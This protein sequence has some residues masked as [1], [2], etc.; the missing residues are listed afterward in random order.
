[1]PIKKMFSA[2][3]NAAETILNNLSQQFSCKKNYFYIS[4]LSF[5]QMKF[6]FLNLKVNFA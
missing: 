1:M 4:V 5:N 2:N 6:S 3:D